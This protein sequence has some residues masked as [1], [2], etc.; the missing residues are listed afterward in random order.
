MRLSAILCMKEIAQHAYYDPDPKKD[1]GFT[2]YGKPAAEVMKR[3]S[4]QS[5]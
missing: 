2:V 4:Q 1:R 5:L 3:W